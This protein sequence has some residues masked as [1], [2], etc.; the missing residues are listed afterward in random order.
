MSK[1]LILEVDRIKEMMGIDNF[2]HLNR[3][4]IVEGRGVFIKNLWREVLELT[5]NG[6][7]ASNKVGNVSQRL[8]TML[9]KHGSSLNVVQRNQ[10]RLAVLRELESTAPKTMDDV[11]EILEKN[12]GTLIVNNIE[13]NISEYVDEVVSRNL[14]D[15]VV[16]DG[17]ELNN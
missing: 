2:Y 10:K 8:T 5:D 12:F 9:E 16:R 6:V 15:E 17:S 4:L 7:L 13:K 14:R 1:N 3:T 11:L